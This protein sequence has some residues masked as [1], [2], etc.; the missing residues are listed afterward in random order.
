MSAEAVT[1]DTD[2]KN[3]KLV[4]TFNIQYSFNLFLHFPDL[5]KFCTINDLLLTYEMHTFY[6]FSKKSIFL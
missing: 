4:Q 1:E 5:I 3:E 6:T 2:V